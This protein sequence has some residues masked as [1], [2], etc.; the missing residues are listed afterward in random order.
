M[1]LNTYTFERYK[2][3]DVKNA[4]CAT[5]QIYIIYMLIMCM[6]LIIIFVAISFTPYTISAALIFKRVFH[7]LALT[8]INGGE[9]QLINIIVWFATTFCSVSC[10]TCQSIT[11]YSLN[12]ILFF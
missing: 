3:N 8:T 12:W 6:L 5:V 9:A 4:F 2:K 10:F 11:R 7:S 1:K